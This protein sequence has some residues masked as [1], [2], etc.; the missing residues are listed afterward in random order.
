VQW[1]FLSPSKLILFYFT[2]SDLC[3][4]FLLFRIYNCL[5]ILLKKT[6]LSKTKRTNTMNISKYTVNP[7]RMED[8]VKKNRKK[9]WPGVN[10]WQVPEKTILKKELVYLWEL[11]RTKSARDIVSKLLLLDSDKPMFKLYINSP[12]E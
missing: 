3:T 10:Y 7:F 9:S 5:T 4:D 12:M 11:W 8:E 6:S 1:I 2:A